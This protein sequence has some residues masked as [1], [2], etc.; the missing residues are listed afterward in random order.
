MKNVCVKASVCLL[1]ALL[2]GTSFAGSPSKSDEPS[3]EAEIRIEQSEHQTDTQAQQSGEQQEDNASAAQQEEGRS[4]SQQAQQTQ[5]GSEQAVPQEQLET[6]GG[7]TNG[8]SILNPQGSEENVQQRS[9]SLALQAIHML[10]E[11]VV[12]AADVA[13]RKDISD[14][15]TDQAYQMEAQYSGYDT[16]ALVLA[17]RSEINLNNVSNE[18][19]QWKVQVD[20]SLRLINAASE[21]NFETVYTSEMK[22]LKSALL[23]A[24]DGY[25]SEGFSSTVISK[26]VDDTY[27]HIQEEMGA[28]GEVPASEQ[29]VTEQPVTEQP[30]TNVPVTAEPT[31]ADAP[32]T[33]AG[34]PDPGAI[35]S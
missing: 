33:D 17:R 5:N 4:E 29:P 23:T 6:M 21:D 35:A 31:A 30:V 2:A 25:K 13:I 19:S 10:N 9:D 24:L 14:E 7:T 20:N 32:E 34:T 3:D 1:S 22:T 28:A 12:K 26:F 15:F 11:A 27:A 16:Q 18:L 8:A